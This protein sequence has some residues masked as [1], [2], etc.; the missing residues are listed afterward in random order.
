MFNIRKTL[1]RIM[2]RTG[3]PLTTLPIFLW[4]TLTGIT[5]YG[6]RPSY[7]NRINESL[8]ASQHY[9]RILKY[10]QCGQ[11]MARVVNINS[12]LHPSAIKKYIPH[13]TIIHHCGPHSGCCRQENEQCVPKTIEEVKLY[14]W[15]IELT[16]RGHKKGIEVIAMKNHTECMC[17]PIN[18]MSFQ[19]QQQQQSSWN[20]STTSSTSTTTSSTTSATTTM[21]SSMIQ[22]LE[23]TLTNLDTQQPSTMTTVIADI[24][25]DRTSA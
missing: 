1:R 20:I 16:S 21:I 22:N 24:D 19:Q 10:A 11:P 13:C 18:S 8:L 17:A 15:T 7:G 5:H 12:E 3:S 23:S 9:N 2:V 25:D 14:F 4:L 6:I